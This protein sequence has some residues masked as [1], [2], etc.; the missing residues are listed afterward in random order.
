MLPAP[1]SADAGAEDGR[2][3]QII[4]AIADRWGVEE[5]H[6]GKRVW[7]LLHYPWPRDLRLTPGSNLEDL[8]SR[9]D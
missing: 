9:D 2:G 3:V 5:H 7:A 8:I 6:G 4:D 1:R